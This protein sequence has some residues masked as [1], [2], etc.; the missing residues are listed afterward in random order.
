MLLPDSTVATG[1]RY[2]LRLRY[3]TGI[4]KLGDWPGLLRYICILDLKVGDHCTLDILYLN[5]YSMLIFNIIITMNC[6]ETVS[7]SSSS[8]QCEVSYRS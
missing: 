8:N 2:G 6:F 3:V 5:A 7:Y 1:I 4:L